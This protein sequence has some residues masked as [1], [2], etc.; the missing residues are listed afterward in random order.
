M[1]FRSTTVKKPFPSEGSGRRRNEADDI[2]PSDIELNLR[3]ALRLAGGVMRYVF[4]AAT[5]AG[6]T[7]L[8]FLFL[9]VPVSM[10]G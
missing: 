2:G 3:H 4:L 5:F 8:V 10:I 7:A 6:V 9:V 1:R